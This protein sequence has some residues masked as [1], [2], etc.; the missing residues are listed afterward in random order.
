[1]S[2]KLV[3]TVALAFLCGVKAQE[4][5]C[6]F[7]DNH[8]ENCDTSSFLSH[9]TCRGSGEDC[10]CLNEDSSSCEVTDVTYDSLTAEQ[11]KTLC[12]TE[13]TCRFYKHITVTNLDLV[14]PIIIYI[15]HKIFWIFFTI[16]L[17]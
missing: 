8:P 4:I 7:L 5:N 17:I 6:D 12:E 1:M 11:C 9:Y 2:F 14:A 13:A 10:T 16:L 15:I 3:L